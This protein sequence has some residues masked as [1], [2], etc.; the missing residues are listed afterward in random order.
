MNMDK[1]KIMLNVYVVF[2]LVVVG[3][4]IFE[5]VDYYIYLG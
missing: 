3:N 1:M 2:I 5:V 4:D